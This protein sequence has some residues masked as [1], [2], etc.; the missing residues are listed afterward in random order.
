MD[1]KQLRV[2]VVIVVW[3]DQKSDIDQEIKSQ[4]E[5]GNREKQTCQKSHKQEQERK[6]SVD[7]RGKKEERKMEKVE[8]TRTA[9]GHI[10]HN[11]TNVSVV[12]SSS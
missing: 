9:S 11:C 3:Q 2:A 8:E 12:P 1:E 6:K 7:H 4:L 10:Q 5:Q